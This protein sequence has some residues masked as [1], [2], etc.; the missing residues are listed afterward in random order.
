MRCLDMK[1]KNREENIKTLMEEQKQE[2]K[3]L[4]EMIRSYAPYMRFPDE[5][6]G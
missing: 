5:K 1:T 3:D 2:I 4:K 6:T